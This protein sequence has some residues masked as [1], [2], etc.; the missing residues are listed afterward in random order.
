MNL[1]EIIN[2]EEQRFE[3]HELTF[4]IEQ[5]IFDRKGV[6]VTIALPY[7]MPMLLTQRVNMI[8]EAFEYAKEYYKR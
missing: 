4:V 2:R 8:C 1:Q 6:R 3:L 5:Y 7:F